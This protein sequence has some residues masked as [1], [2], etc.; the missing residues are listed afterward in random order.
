MSIRRRTDPVITQRIWDA[1]KITVHQ[2]S[3]PTKDR[4]IRH[5]AR[6]YGITEQSAQ[7][8]LNRALEDKLVF[9]KKVQIKSGVDNETL[10]LPTELEDD[11]AHDWYCFKCQRAGLVECCAQCYRVYHKDCHVP[12]NE[13]KKL[14]EFCEVCSLERNNMRINPQT[15][16]MGHSRPGQV[17]KTAC[18]HILDKIVINFFFSDATNYYHSV[19]DSKKAHEFFSIFLK[20]K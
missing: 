11:D 4:I 2:R 13:E 7:D 9:L 15:R 12:A 8:E 3:I 1:I 17:V 14:C 20:G 18:L 5:L 19:E 10:R 16:T 6:V